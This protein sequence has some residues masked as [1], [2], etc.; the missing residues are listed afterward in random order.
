MYSRLYTH[1]LNRY[2]DI[3][4]FESFHHVYADSSLFGIMGAFPP[5]GRRLSSS[6]VFTLMIHQLS[7]LAYSPINSTEMS[8]AKKQLKSA[9]MM[10]LE[11]RGIEVE[12]MG[13]QVRSYAIHYLFH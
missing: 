13:R 4:H 2:G 11:S 8:R 12:D 3:N 9:L 7:L 10:S 1:V 5:A 6:D